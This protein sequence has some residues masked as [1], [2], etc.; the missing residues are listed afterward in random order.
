MRDSIKRLQPEI[1]TSRTDRL[2]PS[3]TLGKLSRVEGGGYK[4][5]GPIFATSGI[6]RR[7]IH[8]ALDDLMDRLDLALEEA[9]RTT[10][11]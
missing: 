1:H 3:L 10:P 6:D 8:R 4:L 2:Y 9:R 5:E 11:K 7:G